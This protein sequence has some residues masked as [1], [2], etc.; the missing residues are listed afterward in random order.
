MIINQGNGRT[1][2]DIKRDFQ[3]TKEFGRVIETPVVKSDV[4]TVKN[5][6]AKVKKHM[7]NL[8]GQRAV[9]LVVSSFASIL[10][11]G[12]IGAIIDN[13]VDLPDSPSDALLEVVLYN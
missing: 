4:K 3:S 6:D 5:N 13:T 7:S 2:E 12:V 11:I 10:T 9:S 8:R 1:L